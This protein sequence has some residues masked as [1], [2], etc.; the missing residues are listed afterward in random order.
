MPCDSDQI[1]QEGVDLLSRYL[2]R[3]VADGTYVQD[4][5]EQTANLQLEDGH[6]FDVVS[7]GTLSIHRCLVR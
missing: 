2:N 6:V 1:H 5:C 4:C 3:C 7:V